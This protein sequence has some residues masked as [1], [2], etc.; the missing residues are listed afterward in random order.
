MEYF[1]ELRRRLLYC[2]IF[3]LLVFGIL[4]FFANPLYQLLTRPL[5][6]QLPSQN[7]IATKITA[8]FLVPVKFSFIVSIF[9]LIPFFFYHLWWFVSPALYNFEK[10]TM[11]AL[12]FPT[13]ILFYLGVLF[14]YFLVLPLLF[15]FFVTATP[16]HVELLPDIGQYLEFALQ[17]LF[18]FGLAFEVPVVVL[19]LVNFK[20]V[21]LSQLKASRRYVIVMAFIVGMLLTPPDVLSQ[22]MLAIPLW[23]LFELGLLWAKLLKI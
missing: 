5:L 3:T 19:V 7:L 15:R 6:L 13:V 21:T 17:L 8:T 14:A 18:A 20:I 4:C 10:K 9:L 16:A 1:I 23:L 12:L 22:T 2:F 11:W